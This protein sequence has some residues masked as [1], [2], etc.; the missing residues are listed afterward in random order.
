MN[1]LVIEDNNEM[2]L[3]L[4]LTL[5]EFG[6]HPVCFLSAAKAIAYYRQNYH[7]I[8]VSIVDNILCDGTGEQCFFDIIRINPDAKVVVISGSDLSNTF[9]QSLKNCSV[10]VLKKP[11]PISRLIACIEKTGGVIP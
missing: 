8:Q 4:K 10:P 7:S 2:N 11:F 3:M 1:V 6:Y 5:V 9:D